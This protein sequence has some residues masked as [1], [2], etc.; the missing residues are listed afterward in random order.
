MTSPRASI[1]TTDGTLN[2]ITEVPP[3]AQ[4]ACLGK[5]ECALSEQSAALVRG[6]EEDASR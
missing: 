5:P 3:N 4:I 1:I 2:R 6:Q